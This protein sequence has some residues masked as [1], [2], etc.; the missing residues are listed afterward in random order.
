MSNPTFPGWEPPLE[1]WSKLPHQFIDL[2]PQMKLSEMRC[3]LY[4]L[5]H[6]WGWGNY[7]GFQG[8]TIDEFMNGRLLGRERIDHGT[9]L[10]KSSVIAG[11]REAVDRRTVEVDVDESD[12]ARI[13]KRYRLRGIMG[14]PEPRSKIPTAEVQN[15]DTEH[16]KDTSKESSSP[17]PAK[18]KQSERER[19][20]L[21][22]EQ[23]FI[24]S[25]GIPS[26][27]L[28]TDKAKKRANVLWYTPLWTIYKLYRPEEERTGKARLR[29]DLT[30]LSN[31]IQLIDA[32]VQHCKEEKLT[33]SAPRS[34]EQVAI[35]I[36]AEGNIQ[37]VEASIDFWKQYV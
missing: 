10:S 29:Y 31:T 9:G 13:K 18:R 32:A 3:T 15:L 17:P 21:A 35:S 22:M 14:K 6:T 37:S 11:L 23:R 26:P 4:L 33:L 36:F 34:I 20:S 25:S 30:S 28:S 5:R 16:N 19:F 7:T 12:K 27:D 2:M 8:M 1:N 24:D